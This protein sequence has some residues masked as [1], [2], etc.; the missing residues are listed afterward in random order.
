MKVFRI[1]CFFLL[2][3]NLAFGQLIDKD[4]SILIES[5]EW[6]FV[7]QLIT[8][9]R[10]FVDGSVKKSSLYFD[11]AKEYIV[12]CEEFLNNNREIFTS[13]EIDMAKHYLERKKTLLLKN[14]S[15][16]SDSKIFAEFYADNLILKLL[17]Q[18]I[19]D[20]ELKKIANSNNKEKNK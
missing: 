8:I 19:L 11:L 14:Q 5:K 17:T 13:E 20:R 9:N 4:G 12:S 7:E 10:M 1:I 3:S 15:I 2:L 16:L 6:N 18:G